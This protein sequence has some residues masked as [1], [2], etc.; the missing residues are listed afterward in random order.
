MQIGVSSGV[1]GVS[2]GLGNVFEVLSVSSCQAEINK[3]KF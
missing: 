2:G 1:I 3:I